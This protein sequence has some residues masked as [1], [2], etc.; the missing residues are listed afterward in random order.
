MEWDEALRELENR[1]ARAQAMGGPE[2]IARQHERGRLTV[3]ERLTALLDPGSW[4]EIGGLWGRGEYD[5]AGNRC[6]T[7][8]NVVIGHGRIDDRPVAIQADD[9]TVRGGAGDAG[10][11][12][13]QAYPE[14]MAGALGMP[15]VRLVDGTGGGGSVKNLLEMDRTYLPGGILGTEWQIVMDLDQV[16][17]I[18]LALGSVAGLGAARLVASHVSIMVRGQSHICVAGPAIAKAAL[19][20]DL[21]IEE[22]G[23]W[24]VASQAGTVDLVADTEEHAFELTRLVL[25]Y[26]PQ[27]RGDLPPR[28]APPQHQAP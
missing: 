14:R 9:F 4:R 24:R 10:T 26:L 11:F 21:T 6:F 22:L 18:S 1:R 15:V 13:K 28:G 12:R 16:P 27:H 25:S 2:R 8:S 7:T 17:V 5:A 3:R 23:G 20:E 19:G